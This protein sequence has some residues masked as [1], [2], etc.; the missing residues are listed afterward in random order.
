M[1]KNIWFICIG[2]IALFLLIPYFAGYFSKDEIKPGLIEQER[3]LDFHP[4]NTAQVETRS[5]TEIY[6]AV[7]TV[8]PRTEFS[9]EAQVTGKIL[10]ILVRPGDFVK[11]GSRLIRLEDNEYRARLERAVQGLRSTEA[12]REQAKQMIQAAQARYTQAESNYRRIRQLFDDDVLSS[13]EAE[14]A[15]AEFLQTEAELKQAKDGLTAAEAGVSQA[16]K[17]VEEAEIALDYTDITASEDAEIAKRLVDPGDLALPGKP[18]LIVQAAGAMRLEA[19]V[20]EGL[21]GNV[22]AGKELSVS[23]ETLDKSVTGVVEEVI[24]SADPT[25]RTF[26][27][28]VGLP[29]IIGLYPGMFGRLL[30]PSGTR[31]AVLVPPEAVSKVGQLETIMVKEDNVWKKYYIKTGKKIEDRIEVLSGLKGN[32][33]IALMG[34]DNA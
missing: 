9:I 33:T 7:G 28:K 6:E 3:I 31:Q 22:H 27:V 29:N 19:F 2:I 10:E 18:L 11:K 30:V 25:T 13:R 16:L 20:R 23:I 14:Q 15:E 26:L 32:E 8:R 21:I 17:I 24:P 12:R 5:I 1:K 4:V 34:S